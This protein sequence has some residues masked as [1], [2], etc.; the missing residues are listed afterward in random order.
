MQEQSVWLGRYKGLVRKL[1]MWSFSLT[2][3][4]FFIMVVNKVFFGG[5]VGVHE[6]LRPE[7][8]GVLA[9]TL[10]SL[11]ALSLLIGG[12]YFSDKKGAIEQDQS[13]FFDI[14]SLGTSGTDRNHVN[15]GYYCWNG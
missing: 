7:E 1:M 10:L 12:I 11:I 15:A 9:V 2:L 3:L 6:M 5:Q 13:G 14:F 8:G 4:L